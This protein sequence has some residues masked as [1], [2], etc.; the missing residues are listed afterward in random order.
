MSIPKQVAS[1]K[2]LIKGS[3]QQVGNIAIGVN[4]HDPFFATAASGNAATQILNTGNSL[5]KL[6]FSTAAERI[7]PIFK[8]ERDSFVES[9]PIKERIVNYVEHNGSRLIRHKLD[10][11]SPRT[12]EAGAQLGI[13]FEDCVKK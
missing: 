4:Q 11:N 10:F 7:M 13:T 12:S 3:T 5:S 1:S 8:K 9:P 2:R 6:T